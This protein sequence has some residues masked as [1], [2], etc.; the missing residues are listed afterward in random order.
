VPL[1]SLSFLDVNGRDVER[2]GFLLVRLM[3][4]T[5][6]GAALIYVGT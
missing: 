2:F 4:I 6:E 3:T 5:A 1:I